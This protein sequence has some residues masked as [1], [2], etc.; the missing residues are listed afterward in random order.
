VQLLHPVLTDRIHPLEDALRLLDGGIIE[1]SN[2][3]VGCGPCLLVGFP[4]DDMKPDAA[5]EYA[6]ARVR[7]LVNGVELFGYLI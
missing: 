1:I 3:I 7:N 4:D 2:Q 6:P 5:A